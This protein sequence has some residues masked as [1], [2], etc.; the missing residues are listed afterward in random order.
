MR[1]PNT[2]DEIINAVLTSPVTEKEILIKIV[3]I[4]NPEFLMTL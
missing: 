1:S 3:E 2:T 4:R